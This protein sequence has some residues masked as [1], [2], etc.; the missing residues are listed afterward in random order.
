MI[1][2]YGGGGWG[3]QCGHITSELCSLETSTVRAP[4]GSGMGRATTK[5]SVPLGATPN[6]EGTL[7]LR[8]DRDMSLS[9]TT[10]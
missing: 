1:V 4:R 10:L 5:S 6:A 3:I 9:S 2:K 8:R 7:D